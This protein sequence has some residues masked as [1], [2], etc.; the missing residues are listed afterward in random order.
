MLTA[1]LLSVT[2]L[3]RILRLSFCLNFAKFT[4]RQ[5]FAITAAHCVAGLS[6]S[7]TSLAVGSQ[8]IAQNPSDT[9]WAARYAIAQFISHGGYN[10]SRGLNDIALVRTSSYIRYT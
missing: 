1:V 7:S 4:V 5:F 6:P 2:R 10:A 9:R 8:N 3:I